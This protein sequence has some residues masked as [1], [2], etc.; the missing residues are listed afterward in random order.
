MNKN[1][2]ISSQLNMVKELRGHYN[3]KYVGGFNSGSFVYFITRQAVNSA[4][5]AAE[6]SDRKYC[7]REIFSCSELLRNISNV[8]PQELPLNLK[9]EF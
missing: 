8:S 3:V 5:L 6:A 7:N 2:I 9:D 4:D 1:M